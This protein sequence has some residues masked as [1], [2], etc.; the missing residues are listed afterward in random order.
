MA[1]SLSL[2]DVVFLELVGGAG[3]LMVDDMNA[4]FGCGVSGAPEGPVVV[5][6]APSNCA[7]VRPQ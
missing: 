4:L 5:E 2:S 7:W 3:R 1:E 6:R